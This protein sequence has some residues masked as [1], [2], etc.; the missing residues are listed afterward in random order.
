MQSRPNKS[1]TA[2]FMPIK[3][4]H[5]FKIYYYNIDTNSDESYFRFVY[6]SGTPSIIK[7]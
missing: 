4:G 7:Y 2:T 5:Q 1:D 3:K 6:D